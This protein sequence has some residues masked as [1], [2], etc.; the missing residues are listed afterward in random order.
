CKTGF[1]EYSSPR[2]RRE[3]EGRK[4]TRRGRAEGKPRGG[5]RW[6]EEK[7]TSRRSATG[8]AGGGGGVGTEEGSGGVRL[9]R[10]QARRRCGEFTSNRCRCSQEPLARHVRRGLPRGSRA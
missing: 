3:G 5:G 4:E 1:L 7:S 9:P 6:G 8:R 2:R 10:G